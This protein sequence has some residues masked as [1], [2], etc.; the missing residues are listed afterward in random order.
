MTRDEFRFLERIRVRWAEIDSQQIV[1]NA[2]YLTY[3]DTAIAGYWRRM[4]LPYQETMRA[5]DGDLYVRKATLEYSG[6]ARY[7]ELID[8]GVR[9]QRIGNSSIEFECGVFKQAHLL[10]SG[11]LIY[12]FADPATQ[13]SRPVPTLLRDWLA[14]FEAGKP[15]VKLELGPWA[16][17]QADARRIRRQVFIEEQRVPE[18]MEWDAVDSDAVHAVAYN[19][20]GAPLGTGRG[21]FDAAGAYRIGR[22][23]VIASMRGTGVGRAILDSLIDAGRLRGAAQ[24]GLSAQT[25]VIPFYLRAGFAVQGEVYDD[26]SIPHI[27][28]TRSLAP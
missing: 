20:L 2:H 3:F 17:L 4:A 5:L 14:A 9:C 26:A 22:M 1:F 6:S 12:V 16:T 18:A 8:A 15:M 23:S 28:M 11:A 7:D 13:S 19:T 24:V 27:E 10:V 25:S 21:F